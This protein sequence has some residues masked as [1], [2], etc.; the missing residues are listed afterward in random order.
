MMT[1]LNIL[2][3]NTG[4][5]LWVKIPAGHLILRAVI[6]EMVQ[7]PAGKITLR[8]DRIKRTW[9]VEIAPFLL[10]KYPVTQALYSA[11]TKECP[12]SFTGEKKPVEN[13]SWADAIIFCTMLSVT[14]GL[15]LYY[16]FDLS[17]NVTFNA[18]ATG[19]RLP[20]EAEWEYACKAGTNEIRYGEIDAIAWY[21]TS[22]ATRVLYRVR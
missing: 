22:P 18:S 12:S 19:Y 6:D 3:I 8:D 2:R 14:S 11:V 20:S 15:E 10:A 16:A 9:D 1:D 4:N 5:L 7:I 17:G 21:K 13:V